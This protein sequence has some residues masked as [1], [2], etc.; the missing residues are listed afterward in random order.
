MCGM[1]GTLD[2]ELAAHRTIKVAE[3][4]VF[5]C[6][7]RRTVGRTTAHVNKTGIIDGLWRG[8]VHWPKSEVHRL[9]DGDL[10]GGAQNSSTENSAE[11]APLRKGEA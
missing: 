8:E 1:Y 2:A 6:L 9:V 11:G 4:T 3:L 7:L 10:G 5:F